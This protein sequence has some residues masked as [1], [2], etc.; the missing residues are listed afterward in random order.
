VVLALFLL[1]TADPTFDEAFRA[2]LLALQRNDLPA[3][4]QNLA[5]A[6]RLAPGNA[7]V[8]VALARTYWKLDRGAEAARAADRAGLLGKSDTTVLS[9]LSIY[10][11]DAGQPLKAAEAEA[12]YCALSP[13]DAAARERAGALYF[14]AAQPLLEQQ[15]FTEA[16]DILKPATARL[17]GSAQLELAL[18][19]AYY[20]MRR[21][22][23]AAAAFL[24]TI[25]IA[26][27]V[28]RP[29]LFLGRFL[30]Q[31][32]S[33]LPEVTARFVAYEKAHPQRAAGYLLHA[34]ALDAQSADA[35]TARVLLEKA[36]AIDDRDASA[37]FEMGVVLDRLERHEDA[38]KEF[39]RSAELD[40]NEPATHYRLSRLYDRLGRQE[41]A[42]RERELHA[43]LVAAQEAIR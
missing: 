27:E 26:P 31:I 36:L 24:R 42:R 1:L 11:A 43:R 30:G 22:D 5:A 25:A 34:K 33:R 16:I 13:R 35:D 15:R 17:T 10:Y 23:D 39:V 38:V 20:G 3:A 4:E 37:H 28:E 6:S 40:P 7:R 8:W 21:F 41:D 2:G 29:Y 32:P 12:A 9:S 18:G 14:Q 19:V